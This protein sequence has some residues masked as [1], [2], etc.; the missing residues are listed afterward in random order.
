M[1]GALAFVAVSAIVSG[2]NPLSVVLTSKRAHVL[3]DVV[4]IPVCAYVRKEMQ[5]ILQLQKIYFPFDD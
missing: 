2:K 4:P 1:I 5:K 3:G